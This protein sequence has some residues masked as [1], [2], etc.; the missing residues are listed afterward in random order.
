MSPVG[1]NEPNLDGYLFGTADSDLTM[2]AA[3][4]RGQDDPCRELATA[5][6]QWH[7]FEYIYLPINN[8][9]Y[10]EQ[11]W[12]IVQRIRVGEMYVDT[13]LGLQVR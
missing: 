9:E 12:G 7:A 2:I 3:Q 11:I 8:G 10:V 6:C 5:E 13:A 4:Y 1:W